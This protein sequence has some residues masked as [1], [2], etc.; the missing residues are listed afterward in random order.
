MISHVVLCGPAD[1][2]AVFSNQQNTTFPSASGGIPVNLLAKGLLNKGVRVTIVTTSMSVDKIWTHSQ[3][4]LTFYIVPQRQRARELAFDFFRSERLGMI[5]VLKTLEFDLIHAHWTYEYALAAMKIK[6][7]LLITAHDAPLKM[8]L[9]MLDPYRFFRLLMA[10]A[11]RIRVK[12]ISFVSSY[13]AEKWKKEMLWKSESPVIPN[14]APIVAKARVVYRNDATNVLSIASDNKVKNIR[15]LL[16]AW[17]YVL[18][19]N[20]CA[21]LDLVGYGLG[22]NSALHNWATDMKLGESIRWHGFADR[23]RVLELLA[24]ADILVHPSIEESFGLTLLESM[25]FGI[26]IVAGK[27]SGAVPFIVKDAGILINVKD[28]TEIA[29]AV[30]S[31]LAQKELRKNLGQKGKKRVSQDFSMDKIVKAYMDEYQRIIE[32][33]ND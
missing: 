9:L 24:A 3:N 32:T 26:P 7:P 18:S 29:N 25:A 16:L 13:L 1:P 20:P 6:K 11:V 31:L 23:N 17:P 19:K 2:S 8:F 21:K 15:T 4:L 28:P 30:V 27:K 33:S 22:E 5:E 12:N 10:C 14:I